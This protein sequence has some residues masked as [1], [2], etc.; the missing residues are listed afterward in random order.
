GSDDPA[1]LIVEGTKHVVY[2]YEKIPEPIVKKGSVDVKYVDRATGEV[3][4]FDEAALTTIKDNVPEGEG[5]NTAKKDFSGYTFAGMTTES[6]AANG[7]VVADTT[8]HVIY[9]YD[10]IPEPVVERGSVDVV[11]VDEQGNVLPGG[12]LSDVKKDAP[13][14]ETYTTEQKPFEGYTF[15]R[16]GTGSALANG[17]V[18]KGI[19]H[20]IYV[21]T[22]NPEAPKTGSV[23]V[24]FVDKTTGEII[25]GTSL[26]VVKDDVPV[27]EGYYTTPKDLTDKGY[28]FVGV[29]EGSDDPAGLIVE[30]TKHVVY[31]YEKIP[32]P[33]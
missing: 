33:I 17:E 31:E 25:E 20:V 14:G 2:E 16:M 27:G 24:K 1:G 6:A 15:H 30:G 28:Q 19:Q 18:T 21:Y 5:Y 9:A 23:D 12:E 3:L 11:Y 13:V 22:K 4:P 7:T 10:K 32:E 8:L 29:R 26:E